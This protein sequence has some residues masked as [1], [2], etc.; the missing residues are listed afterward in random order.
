MQARSINGVL[1]RVLER[2][3][4]DHPRAL[5]ENYWQHQRRAL[6][7]GASMIG[8]GVACLIHAVVPAVFV[9]TASG[10]VQRLYDE[11]RAS[12]RLSPLGRVPP[13][14]APCAPVGEHASA[15]AR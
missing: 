15:A 1:D 8:G 9:S 12:G 4:L 14:P 13:R 3:F 6:H 10:T 11:L 2:V 7:F 5:G